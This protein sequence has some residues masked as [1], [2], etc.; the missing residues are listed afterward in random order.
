MQADGDGFLYPVVNAELCIDCSLC[1]EVCPC[2]N[3]SES[4]APKS[5]LS[6]ETRDAVVRGQSSSGGAFSQL[7][8]HIL[9]KGGVVFGARFDNN[10][11]VIHDY[12]ETQNGL[13]A[14]YGS[15]YVQSVI[16][17][18]YRKVEGFLKAYREV[19][20]SGTPCQIAGLR[21]YLRIEYANLLTVEI[22]CH[23]VPSPFVWQ[24]YLKGIKAKDITDI[25]F[26]DKRKGWE[27]Y[28]ISITQGNGSVFFQEHDNNSYMQLYLHGVIAR[29]S[30]FCCLAKDGH[31]GADVTLGDCWGITKM[32][33][34]YP[35]VQHGVS[36]VFCNTEK[37]Q[38]AAKDANVKGHELSYD[39][40]VAFNG[41]LTVKGKMPEER[42]AFWAAFQTHENKKQVINQFAKPY[43]PGF[44]LRFKHF[45]SR[46]LNRQ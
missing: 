15:K 46:M 9:N 19:L 24:E 37:G 29:P 23:S 16:G 14:F 22:A 1:K 2:L 41:G 5:V 21:N 38:A 39:Q 32:V 45:V 20:F 4:K 31:S 43:L 42:A 25:N 12:A 17:D 10:W 28:G 8:E 30:C 13:K 6:F 35:N 7:A 40:V 27:R 36:F 11:N 44:V 26:R 18:C 34:G 3:Q 33:P